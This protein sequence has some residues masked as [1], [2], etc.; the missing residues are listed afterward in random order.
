M[1]LLTINFVK[2][3][4]I[5]RRIFLIFLTNILKQTWNSFNTNFQYHWKDQKSSYQVRLILGLFSHLIAVI[6]A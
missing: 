4:N 6:L 5:L 2:Y 3:S 1:P